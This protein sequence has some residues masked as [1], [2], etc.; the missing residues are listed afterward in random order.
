MAIPAFPSQALCY[1]APKRWGLL[2]KAE[3]SLLPPLLS[4]PPTHPSVFPHG[5]HLLDFLYIWAKSFP[6]DLTGAHC[7]TAIQLLSLVLSS[8]SSPS[9]TTSSPVAQRRMLN[10]FKLLILQ[11]RRTHKP[12]EAA[13]LATSG[14]SRGDSMKLRRPRY[15]VAI[16][17]PSSKDVY[18][19]A[20][21][22]ELSHAK[23]NHFAAFSFSVV[24]QFHNNLCRP[25]FLDLPVDIL[26]EEMTAHE[27]RFRFL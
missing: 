16:Q 19:A 26:A 24:P 25:Q 11:H 27:I 17:P 3:V 5:S 23:R 18:T 10:D 14:S 22:H 20:E 2:P 6:G 12:P 21:G 9:S 1:T 7:S 15:S 13:S 4:A 8:A